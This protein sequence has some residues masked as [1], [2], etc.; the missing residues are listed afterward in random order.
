[1]TQHL[2]SL[3]LVCLILTL[4]WK[5]VQAQARAYPPMPAKPSPAPP[6]KRRKVSRRD[7]Y[8]DESSEEEEEEEEPKKGR[9]NGRSSQKVSVP[10]A[11]PYL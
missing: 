9:G 1:M 10:S 2:M 4:V 3:H 11:L 8:S 7:E 5:I 6:P